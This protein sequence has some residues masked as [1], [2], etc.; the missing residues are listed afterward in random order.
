MLFFLYTLLLPLGLLI[1]LPAW[2]KKTKKRGG[3]G[4]GVSERWGFF[5]FPESKVLKNS[6]FIHAV[7]VGEALIAK[8]LVTQ[9]LEEH[10]EETFIIAV[11]TPTAMQAL[12]GFDHP[13]VQKVYNT[14]DLPWVVGK[15]LKRYEPKVLVLMESE[16]WPNLIHQASH[17]GIPVAIANARLSE[18]SEK[19]LQ[20]FSSFA[21]PLLSQISWLGAQSQ[22]DAERWANAGVPES[23]I[24]V[25]GS[26]KFDPQGDIEK[27]PAPKNAAF[28]KEI[29][30][31]KPVVCALSTH[32]GEEK[33]V[34]E[35]AREAGGF[36]FIIPRHVER[37]KEVRSDLKASLMKV[38]LKTEL[39][40]DLDERQPEQQQ[41]EACDAFVL[42]TT[43]ELMSWLPYVQISVVG[44]SFLSKGGQNPVEPILCDVPTV[45]GPDMDNFKELVQEL[46]L[47]NGVIQTSAEELSQ[48]IA[49]IINQPQYTTK[50]IQQS[51]KVILKHYGAT[52]R[53]ITGL[54]DLAYQSSTES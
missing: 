6:I 17:C 5:V 50:L 23:R 37:R 38:V 40:F 9:W 53:S 20:K 1:S 22:T 18:K 7:S 27:D 28:L 19:N 36:P 45:V 31:G 12:G 54:T 16:L 29:S 2:L 46:T 47:S 4:T 11:S 48:E 13:R 14:I 32:T 51:R 30:Q 44:K 8:K 43:G 49:T 35:A 15:F 33:L 42:D 26:I 34:A 41:V 24:V 25:T 52:Q 10:K 39:G 3:F 21:R